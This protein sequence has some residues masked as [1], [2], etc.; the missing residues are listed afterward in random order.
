LREELIGDVET[1]DEL[2]NPEA[3][4]VYDLEAEPGADKKVQRLVLGP[5]AQYRMDLRGIT[6]P[7]VRAAIKDFQMQMNNWKSQ[8]DPR[9]LKN[10]HALDSAEGVRW[11]DPKLGLTVVF[12]SESN[13]V[14]VVT[15]FLTEYTVPKAPGLGHCAGYRTPDLSGYRTLV[16]D[17]HPQDRA[18]GGRKD[19]LLPSPPWKREKPFGQPV[20][21]GPGESGSQPDGKSLSQ[22]KP[23][24]LGIPGEDSPHPNN[25]AT[26][27][28]K[29]RQNLA[30][31]TGGT[32]FPLQRQKK[33]QGPAKKY[34]ERYYRKNKS[35]IKRLSL[36]WYNKHK[37]NPLFKKYK[38]RV[39]D[40]PQ[41]FERKPGGE[42][43]PADRSKEWRK[44]NE[45]KAVG[46]VVSDFLYKKMPPDMDPESWYD[47]GKDT[48]WLDDSD[49]RAPAHGD[50]DRG[51]V[52]PSGPGKMMPQDPSY[53]NRQAA[54]ISE[55]KA[56]CGADLIQRSVK[57]PVKLHRVNAD[58]RVWLFNVT[59]SKGDPYRVRVKALSKGNVQDPSKMDVLVSCS[60]PFWQWQGPE[61]W[62]QQKR[63]L[64]GKPRGTASQPNV[65]DPS[66]EHG[67]CK[68]VLAVLDRFGTFVMPH[69]KVKLGSMIQMPEGDLSRLDSVVSRYL[70]QS[71]RRV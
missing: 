8:Q 64:Y 21:N 61:Y 20:I 31:G 53:A 59:G 1:G 49:E 70:I 19:R 22:D 65:K 24:T 46:R 44:E 18:D 58:K 66:M 42:N 54:L 39:E 30:S 51:Q 14:K 6:V 25:P 36:R 33:Q 69:K 15:T 4:A 47:R 63:Y 2:N 68:H 57:I 12:R 45:K 26:I 55:I 13:G 71:L 5:H 16:E 32:P 10:L 60:C 7:E 37:R 40:F 9:Y 3:A 62:A 48:M 43:A 28:P 35:D 27:T 56:L 17:P 50:I 41:R 52:F 29:R 34:Y 11:E 67:A 23:R 38:E